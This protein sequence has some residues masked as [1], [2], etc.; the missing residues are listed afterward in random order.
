[1]K[2]PDSLTVGGHNYKVLKDYKFKERTDI[3]GQCDHTVL[4]IRLLKTDMSGEIA[5][6]KYENNFIHEMLHAIDNT[7]NNANLKEEDIVRLSEGLYQ[8]LK[9][10]DMLK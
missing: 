3:H 1:M 2:I 4:E 6:S 9:V 8:V 7:Y 5:C 10:N